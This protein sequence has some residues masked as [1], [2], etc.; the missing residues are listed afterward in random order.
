M[1]I[2][3]EIQPLDARRDK[4][5]HFLLKERCKWIGAGVTSDGTIQILLVVKKSLRVEGK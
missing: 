3:S 2:T 4:W 1:V 5:I